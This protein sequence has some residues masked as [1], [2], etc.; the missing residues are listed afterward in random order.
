MSQ[1][2]IMLKAFQA[3]KTLTRKICYEDLGIIESGARVTEMRNKGI[4]IKTKKVAVI[5]RHGKRVQVAEWSLVVK[6]VS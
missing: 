4:N 6:A 5:N 2:Q 1:Y 3:G